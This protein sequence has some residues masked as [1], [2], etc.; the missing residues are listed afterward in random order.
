MSTTWK[1]I[2]T[3][4]W[5]TRKTK[6]KLQNLFFMALFYF[7]KIISLLILWILTFQNIFDWRL[8]I[9]W[10]IISSSHALSPSGIASQLLPRIL[11]TFKHLLSFAFGLLCV[12]NQSPRAMPHSYILTV[13]SRLVTSNC[14]YSCGGQS[15]CSHRFPLSF[16]APIKGHSCTLFEMRPGRR[17]CLGQWDVSGGGCTTSGLK[18]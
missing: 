7:E 1:I 12:A 15:G 11:R 9:P 5:R 10:L 18:F 2:S 13:S 3:K 17:T 4:A 14:P 8:I 16:Q 6:N